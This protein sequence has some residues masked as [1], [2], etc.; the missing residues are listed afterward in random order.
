[1]KIVAFMLSVTL[2]LLTCLKIVD[3]TDAWKLAVLA[4]FAIVVTYVAF[5]CS[6][7]KDEIRKEF[8]RELYKCQLL[9]DDEIKKKTNEVQ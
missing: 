4:I 2:V 3:K 5:F 1:M 9:F 6:M 8:I 7:R